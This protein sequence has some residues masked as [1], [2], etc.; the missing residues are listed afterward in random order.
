MTT[1]GTLAD[2]AD[3]QSG[4]AFASA[5]FTAD[6]RRGPRLLRGDN[7][8]Q[9]VLRWE[10]AKYWPD[11]FNDSRYWLE[12]GDVVV[13]MDRPWIEAGLKFAT[14]RES[15]L[16]ALLVQRVARLRAKPGNDQRY[17]HYVVAS[18]PF[19][20]HILGIQ[21]GT[22][23][24]HV[25]GAQIIGFPLAAHRLRE[26]CAI[27][28]VLGALDDKIAANAKLV[29]SAN[30]LAAALTRSALTD[31]KQKLS[32]VAALTMGSSPPGSSYNEAGEG[33][34]FYQG[35]RDFGVRFPS[36]RVW[37]TEPVRMAAPADT[38]VSVRAPVGRT[39][40][41]SE[42]TCIGR[43]LAAVRSTTG[44]PMTLFHLLR[45]TPDIWAPY[46]AEGTVF[47]SINK[48]QLAGLLVGSV[49]PVEADALETQLGGLEARIASALAE[50]DRLAET[51]DALLPPLMSGKLRVKD[52]ERVVER[53]V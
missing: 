33:T 16:P 8:G 37:T 24:P 44:H 21:T 18:R 40:L 12:S 2:I 22:A 36:N 15:D 51:R 9:G 13:A 29:E 50:S 23:V 48:Q 28:D 4:F 49:D 53:V 3:L 45:D 52:A 38:L 17:L 25:S 5:R 20:H 35:V 1:S 7:I 19:T 26:Q 30:D 10:G 43:G 11:S 47:G 42:V 41:A 27:A 31:I 34:V 32:D 14:V 46:E 39:N 6:P